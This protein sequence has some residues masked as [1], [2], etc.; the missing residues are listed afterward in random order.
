MIKKSLKLTARERLQ[1]LEDMTETGQKL[2][3]LKTQ[4]NIIK[5]NNLSH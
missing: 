4:A 5:A 3:K 2:A 1:I